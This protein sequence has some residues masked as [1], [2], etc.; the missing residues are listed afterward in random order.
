MTPRAQVRAAA[1]RVRAAMEQ[2]EAAWTH[3]PADPIDL[4]LLEA[5]RALRRLTKPRKEKR[6]G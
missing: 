4:E 2:W 5:Y 6:R 3:A 1:L